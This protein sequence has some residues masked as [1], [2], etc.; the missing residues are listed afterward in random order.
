MTVRVDPGDG[1]WLS[2]DD[3]E[4]GGLYCGAGPE[5]QMMA[6]GKGKQGLLCVCQYGLELVR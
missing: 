6:A 3:Q 2:G 1:A 4:S 5:E